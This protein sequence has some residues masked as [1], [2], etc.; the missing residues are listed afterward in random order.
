MRA[1]EFVI[2]D[3]NSAT[4]RPGFKKE[5]WYRGRY[6]LRAEARRPDKYEIKYNT[7]GLIIT[8]FDPETKSMWLSSAGIANARFIVTGNHMEVSTVYVSPEYQ[9]QGIAS[10]MYNFARE[11]G[12]EIQP[13][14]NQTAQ[15]KA[16]WAGGAGVGKLTPDEPPAPQPEKTP[17]VAVSS[18]KQSWFKKI[19]TRKKEIS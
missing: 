13:S 11:L 9:R 3:Y 5:K 6:L 7:K 16:F 2:D 19:F 17:S 12:N 8:V 10:A 1:H 18:P 14:T 4:V 15:G